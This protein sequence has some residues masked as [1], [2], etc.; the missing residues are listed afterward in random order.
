MISLRLEMFVIFVYYENVMFDATCFV[1][2]FF[3]CLIIFQICNLF[4]TL[5]FFLF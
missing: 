5:F 3:I 4:I 2:A 1:F